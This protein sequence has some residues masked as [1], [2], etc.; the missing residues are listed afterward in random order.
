M[1][2]CP[3]NLWK[4]LKER[5]EQQK[6]LIWPSTNHEWNGL[7]LQDFKF[8]AEYNHALHSI[9]SKLKFSEKEPSEADKIE[10]TIVTSQNFNPRF[11]TLIS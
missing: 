5:Y 4:A 10:R 2:R 8:V 3:H 11:R 9:R 7:R 6:E 1:E